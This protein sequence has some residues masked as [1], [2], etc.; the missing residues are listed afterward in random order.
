M[1]DL[2]ITPNGAFGFCTILNI[3]QNVLVRVP[4]DDADQNFVTGVIGCF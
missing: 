4:S 1:H 3:R 2:P